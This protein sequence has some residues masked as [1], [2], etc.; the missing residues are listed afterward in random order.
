MRLA[1]S[2]LLAGSTLFAVGLTA[3]LATYAFAE[4]EPDGTPSRTSAP[5]GLIL[6]S[7]AFIAIYGGAL[8]GSI[9]QLPYIVV[10]AA[11]IGTLLALIFAWSVGIWHLVSTVP[12][13]WIAAGLAFAAKRRNRCWKPAGEAP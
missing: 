3:F 1:G 9:R 4:S 5:L 11:A 10:V 12:A 6:I 13:A 7:A 8:F 2:I